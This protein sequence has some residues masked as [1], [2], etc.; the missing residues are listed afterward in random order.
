MLEFLELQGSDALIT[1]TDLIEEVRARGEQISERNLAYYHTQGLLPASVRVGTRTGAYPAV[2]AQLAVWVIRSRKRGLSIEAIRELLPMWRHLVRSRSEGNVSLAEIEYLARSQ[3]KSVEANYAIPGLVA[4]VF[5]CLC[6]DCK[7]EISWTDKAS[8][9]IAADADITLGF[10]LAEMD[11][12]T[13]EA[14]RVAWTQLVLPGMG[15]P[16]AADGPTTIVLG[17][18][19][20]IDLKTSCDLHDQIELDQ[21]DDA[22]VLDEKEVVV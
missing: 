20:G 8:N 2:V 17:I 9:V 5:S 21:L 15:A 10:T 6:P 22:A 14:R 19:V 12:S 7:S 4:E 18:P 3:V 16:T 1:K 13:G 11:D